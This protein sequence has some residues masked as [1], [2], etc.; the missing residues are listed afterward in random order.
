MTPEFPREG[1]RPR[2]AQHKEGS[3]SLSHHTCNEGSRTWKVEHSASAIHAEDFGHG[4]AGPLGGA[5][6]AVLVFGAG[7]AFGVLATPRRF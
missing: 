5:P 3:V 2:L 1:A 6:R 7:G 4:H